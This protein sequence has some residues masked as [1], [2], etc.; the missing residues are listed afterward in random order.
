MAVFPAGFSTRKY[1]IQKGKYRN[2]KRRLERGNRIAMFLRSVHSF[3][4][5]VRQSA[6]HHSVSLHLC[7]ATFLSFSLHS[8][9]S[10][11]NRTERKDSFHFAFR[12]NAL[13]RSPSRPDSPFAQIFPHRA[14]N[15]ELHAIFRNAPLQ[16]LPFPLPARK[17]GHR[18]IG[19]L[20]IL[21]IERKKEGRKNTN[22][23][24]PAKR[25]KRKQR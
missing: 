4:S 21:W 14:G 25:K 17:E 7:Y 11:Q 2:T 15:M 16:S 18:L 5:I 3:R 8:F 19:E 22:T 9:H 12:A 23:S 13:F 24:P 20:E 1:K 6:S 10:P